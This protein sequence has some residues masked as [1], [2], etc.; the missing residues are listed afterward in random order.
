MAGE[1][2]GASGNATDFT[3]MGLQARFAW[4]KS[5]WETARRKSFVMNFMGTSS[6][7]MIQ[8][9]TELTSV[10]GASKAVIQL[11]AELL[12]DG[13]AGDGILE[14]NED[15]LRAFEQE[16][17]YDQLRTAT[18]NKGRVTDKRS[19][20]HFRNQS[21][22][23]LG[24]FFGD[25]IDQLA[26][27]TLSGIDYDTLNNG[28]ARNVAS[29]FLLLTYRTDVTAPSANR[30]LRVLADGSIATGATASVLAA[31]LMNYK[32]LVRA[33]AFAK[34][35][36]MRGIAVGS[37][38]MYHVF[39]TPTGMADLRLD[40]DFLAN[41]REAGVRGDKN[42]LFAGT[43]SVMLDGMIVHEYRYVYNTTGLT[44]T[45]KWGVGGNVEG[46]RALM[47][48][49]QAMGFADFGAPGWVEK[50]FDYGNNHGIATNKI[51]G[52]LK[53]QFQND[54]TDSVEDYGVICIDSALSE[55]G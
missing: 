24:R 42:T 7:A 37:D 47:C 52:M 13:V 12:G 46:Q 14:G 55:V 3:A 26:F 51:F 44:A 29:S 19:T 36:G 1:H 31:D 22:D 54:F 17:Q 30:H 45:N 23:K 38:E 20:I 43:S 39:V 16:I 34:E 25:R 50:T 11:V 15:I 2:A 48:G 32:S 18:R 8:R 33:K 27:L 21:K 4:A 5:V 53:P 41:I 9:I 40:A 10:N 49:A 28:A 6:N 35:T